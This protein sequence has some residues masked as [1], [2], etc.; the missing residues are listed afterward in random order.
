MRE[1]LNRL[2]ALT[3][4]AL[5]GSSASTNAVTMLAMNAD[6]NYNQNQI[7]LV[8]QELDKVILMLRL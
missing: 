2:K 5:A 8:I 1:Q 7:R 3:D 4:H 6:V